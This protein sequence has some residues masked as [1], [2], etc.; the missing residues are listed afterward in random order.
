MVTYRVPPELCRLLSNTIFNP[1]APLLTYTDKEL[2]IL[3]IKKY[4]K[5]GNNSDALQYEV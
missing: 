1:A 2:T 5:E 3:L 4:I